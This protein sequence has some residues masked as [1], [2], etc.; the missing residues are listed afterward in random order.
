MSGMR[1][2]QPEAFEFE[3]ESSFGEFETEAGEYELPSGELEEGFSQPCDK[4]EL[5]T[6]KVPFRIDFD[7]F[8]K[9][10]CCAIGRWMPFRTDRPPGR[11]A[12]CFV[13][14][15]ERLLW[16]IHTEMFVKK[17]PCVELQARYCR[18]K[19]MTADVTIALRQ[20]LNTAC[21]PSSLCK[22]GVCSPSIACPT[23]TQHPEFDP[24]SRRCK[25]VDVLTRS[26]CDN[27]KKICK[28]ADDLNDPSSR[29]KCEKARASCEAALQRSKSCEK[30]DL[31][32]EIPMGEF[33]WNAHEFEVA[34]R[35]T[36]HRLDCAAGCPGG[37]TEAQCAPIV[38]QAI[39]EAI[40][41]ANIA[42]KKLDVS[43]KTE[44]AKRDA[45][46]KRTATKFRAFF[47]HDP[48]TRLTT[49][50]KDPSG[51]SIVERFREVAK[52]LAGGRQI[53]FRCL[54][55]R[56][57]CV[58]EDLTCCFPNDAAFAHQ[59]D[60]PNVVHL[61]ASFWNPVGVLRGLPIETYRGAIIL[62]EML[63]I[64]FGPTSGPGG[65]LGDTGRRANAHCHEIFALRA[66]GF[67]QET[68]IIKRCPPL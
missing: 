36:K 6:L 62:H 28:L 41:L 30:T 37:L 34:I 35:G 61:C 31:V 56:V 46:A 18:R 25:Q 32:G 38:R 48:L 47:G 9:L 44:P 55:T 29:E 14:K 51:V 19:G 58:E 13:K 4:T 39:V 16:N 60:A 68:E 57:D 64:L 66:A 2:I 26:I 17:I 59:Q 21:P 54:P 43:T 20:F 33:E 22:T 10:V 67:G 40:K 63:H 24:R 52:E 7:E 42:A 27:A 8:Q 65:F 3:P 11:Q 1:D 50:G 15:H 53:V 12:R 5:A 23:S 45:D 49:T